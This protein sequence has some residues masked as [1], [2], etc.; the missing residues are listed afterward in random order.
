[1]PH[2]DVDACTRRG[3]VV[4]TGARVAVRARRA[5]AGADP[6]VRP[7]ASSTTPSR[8]GPGRWQTTIGRE[9]HG[10]HARHRRLRDDRRARRRLRRGARDARARL[11]PRR[12]RSSA[13]AADG[14][15]AEPDLDALC[16]R[17]GR[18]SACTSSCRRRRVGIVTARA[19]RAD[20]AGRAARQH[21]PRRAGRAGRARGCARG[22]PARAR[23]RSTCST[24]SRPP[25]TRSS[26][27]AAVLATPHLGYVT[28]ETYETLLR[29]RR[30][31]RWTRSPP[32]AP[33][34][35][36]NPEALEAGA[37]LRGEAAGRRCASAP[38]VGAGQTRPDAPPAVASTS[39]PIWATSSSSDANTASSRSRSHT[40]TTSRL[41]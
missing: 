31:P 35:V 6:R 32:G 36:A 33:I 23:G 9:L 20:E 8:C 34:G 40:S 29:R 11:G 30:S 16:A 5:H 37:R 28:W 18:A 3:I 39:R 38:R 13:R 17:F 15:E 1:M 4:C 41:P 12:R 27:I 21:G 7:A 10:T 14:Y 26:R 24:R 2:I 19:S 25:A 22:R